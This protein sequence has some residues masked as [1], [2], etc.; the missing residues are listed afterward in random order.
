MAD[1]ASQLQ[2]QFVGVIT[3]TKIEF[4]KKPAGFLDHLRY[5]LT[6]LPVSQRFQHLHFLREQRQRIMNAKSIDDIFE[7]L[8]DFWDYTDYALLQIGRASC[9]ERV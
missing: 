3:N 2:D 7:I 1:Q 6:T 5:T 8:D 9:R 4:S